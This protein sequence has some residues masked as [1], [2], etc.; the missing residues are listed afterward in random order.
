MMWVHN[1]LT[2]SHAISLLG[3]GKAYHEQRYMDLMM[4]IIIVLN[5]MLMHISDTKHG[6][7]PC[8][9]RLEKWSDV[10]LNMDRTSAVVGSC[11]FVYRRIFPQ[12]IAVYEWNDN[13]SYTLYSW[14]VA[15]VCL[16][17]GE[18][19]NN[20]HLYTIFHCVWHF[21]VFLQFYLW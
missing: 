4:M 21:I 1:V 11:Y 17:I 19:T 18:Y 14:S 13:I 2:V 8:S 12:L 16:A 9:K 20:W 15:M 6:L 3:I 7:T 5:S 10:F